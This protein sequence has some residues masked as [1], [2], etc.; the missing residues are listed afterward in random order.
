MLCILKKMTDTIRLYN[1]IPD[2][3]TGE[4]VVESCSICLDNI[5][6]LP[7]YKLPECNHNFHSNCLIGW[8]RI[9]NGCPICRGTDNMN[10]LNY[11]SNGTIFRHILSF[12]KSKKNKSL[13]LKRV[14]K[15]YLRLKENYHT[16][17]KECIDFE[18]LNKKILTERRKTIQ[19]KY[20]AWRIFRTIEREISSLPIA[21]INK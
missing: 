17:N 8:L 11:R 2:V 18:K 16:K 19:A 20:T 15:K 3:E 1:S 4:L 13:K 5:N 12:C 7:T 14:Y 10:S 6:S 9:N 21:Q